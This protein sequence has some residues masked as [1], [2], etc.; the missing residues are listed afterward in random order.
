MARVCNSQLMPLTPL[1]TKPVLSEYEQTLWLSGSREFVLHF[2][3]LT[4]LFAECFSDISVCQ[5]FHKIPKQLIVTCFYFP[6][7]PKTTI[8][9]ITKT[10]ENI[11]V[12]H[13]KK[14]LDS[15]GNT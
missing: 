7:K 4:Q 2:A 5:H 13:N 9:A 12:T 15:F 3:C 1:L 14:I 8:T 10:L 11:T 6:F